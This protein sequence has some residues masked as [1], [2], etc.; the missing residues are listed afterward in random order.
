MWDVSLK[1]PNRSV[2]NIQ[3]VRHV[4][5]LMRNLISAGQ[6]NDEGHN[7]VFNNGGWKVTKGAMVVARGKKTGTLYVNSSCRIII[8]IADNSMTSDLWHYRLGHMSEKGIRMLHY[9]GKLHGLK[10]ADHS[11]CE[12]CVFGN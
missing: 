2:W 6:L 7:V 3:K 1:M 4:L 9:D 5:G 11:L 12:R 8:T 10:E